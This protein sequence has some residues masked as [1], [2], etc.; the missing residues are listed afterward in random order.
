MAPWTSYEPHSIWCGLM[1]LRFVRGPLRKFFLAALAPI[2][3]AAVLVTIGLSHYL[4]RPPFAG[5][6][7]LLN[8]A[9]QP[10]AVLSNHEIV[11]I[12]RENHV[13][14]TVQ[15]VLRPSPHSGRT[16]EWAP[17][18]LDGN[19]LLIHRYT[20]DFETKIDWR[21]DC[22]IALDGEGNA[23]FRSL[24]VDSFQFAVSNPEKWTES[25]GA[26]LKTY[27]KD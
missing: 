18:K 26:L 2:I 21:R 13:L 23:T 16:V 14:M 17:V 19:K 12:D 11:Y 20:D 8:W 5:P 4:A 9:E 24:S 3:C 6:F 10:T 27:G 7:I 25:I 1:N 15:I 22:I